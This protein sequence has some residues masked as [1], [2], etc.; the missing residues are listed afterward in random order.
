MEHAI[1]GAKTMNAI[2]RSSRSR[3]TAL[4]I[5]MA[6]VL[7]LFAFELQSEAMQR[8]IPGRKLTPPSGRR[9]DPPRQ[10]DPQRYPRRPEF[11]E[12]DRRD[13]RLVPQGVAHPRALIRVFRELKLNEGQLQRLTQ[14]SR[15]SG[16]Q[17][18]MLNRL[19]KAQSDLLDEALYGENFDPKLVEKRAAELSATQSEIIKQQAR[20]MSRDPP[21][22]NA[23]AECTIPEPALTRA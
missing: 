6:I 4:T 19:R 13:M 17:I 2:T 8:G 22:S 20:I 3:L 10:G 1:S 7:T 5:V 23:G 16:N 9:D 11:T 15:Q 14:L 18:P 21:D 12:E